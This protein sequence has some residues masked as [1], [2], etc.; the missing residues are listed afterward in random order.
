MLKKILNEKLDLY[1]DGILLK[2]EAAGQALGVLLQKFAHRG[3]DGFYQVS[4]SRVARIG[5]VI[6]RFFMKKA[7]FIPEFGQAFGA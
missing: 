7:N 6:T 2:N 3:N 5:K 4:D 1:E